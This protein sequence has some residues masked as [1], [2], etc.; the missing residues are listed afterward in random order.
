MTQIHTTN[1]QDPN[2][3]ATEALKA[4]EGIGNDHRDKVPIFDNSVTRIPWPVPKPTPTPES[5]PTIKEQINLMEEQFGKL[6][7]HQRDH[8]FLMSN[9]DGV[10]EDIVNRTVMDIIVS[11]SLG[12]F[13]PY[14]DNNRHDGRMHADL[15]HVPA[16]F[17]LAGRPRRFGDTHDALMAAREVANEET[18]S[19]FAGYD[20]EEVP[21][22]NR[23][24][25]ATFITG[26][27]RPGQV[28]IA[29]LE[30]SLPIRNIV[31]AHWLPSCSD[32]WVV[33]CVPA[34]QWEIEAVGLKF[35]QRVYSHRRAK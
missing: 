28:F 2:W 16:T 22:A 11:A 3:G 13:S 21:L 15:P 25:A 1:G 18:E 24:L 9:R 6:A 17:W 12:D 14:G 23:R 29:D 27:P 26:N 4:T 8:V 19:M 31:V 5:R 20:P 34:T 33:F 7:G 35:D 32:T 30:R 10:R